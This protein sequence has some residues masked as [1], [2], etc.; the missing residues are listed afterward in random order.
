MM[1]PKLDENGNPKQDFL[2]KLQP[3]LAHP[4][5]EQKKDHKDKRASPAVQDPENYYA[6]AETHKMVLGPKNTVK[7]KKVKK[8]TATKKLP[9]IARDASLPRGAAKNPQLSSLT[10]AVRRNSQALKSP[11]AA[12]YK[13]V[14]DQPYQS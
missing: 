8:V 14:P 13:P 12:L 6:S 3:E 1:N 5:P 11:L 7:E 9:P 2:G 10:P 4:P